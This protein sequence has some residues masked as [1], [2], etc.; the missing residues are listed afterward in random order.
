MYDELYP[1]HHN[2][3][4]YLLTGSSIDAISLMYIRYNSAVQHSW[5]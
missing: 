1:L 5:I 4:V 2:G 3:Y